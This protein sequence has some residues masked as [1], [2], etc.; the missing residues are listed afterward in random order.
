MTDQRLTYLLKVLMVFVLALYAGA[1]V[2]EI[3]ARIRGVVYVLIAS[4]FLAY[5]VY[6]AV[7]RLRRYVPLVAA[8]VMVYAGVLI[9][10]FVCAVFVLPHIIDDVTMLTKRYPELAANLNAIV[11]NPRDPIASRFPVWLQHGIVKLPDELVVWLQKLALGSFGRVIVVVT[12]TAAAMAVLIIVPV[13]TAYLLLDLDHLKAS[14]ASVVP[15]ERWRTTLELLS[16]IDAVIGGF[17]RG[18]LLVALTVG[19]LITVALML[20]HV[21]YAFLFG[22]LAALGDLVP[23][24]GAVLAYIPAVISAGLANGWVNALLVTLAF[25]VIFETEGHFIAPNIV[26]K[27]VR[28]SAFVVIVALL[29]GAEVA[30]IFGMLVAVPIAG[31]VRVVA[32]RLLRAAKAQ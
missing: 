19:A 3:L 26:G 18:Q 14:L 5:L 10:L 28:L 12:G 9:F 29:I 31:V 32:L 20:L 24:I 15:A 27:Q 13:V 6:P 7:T 4:I 2:L 11:S 23:Y 8:I 21:P 16:E 1:F 30:G 17:V 25:V 22:L